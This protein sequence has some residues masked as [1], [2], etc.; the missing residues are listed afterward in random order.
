MSVHWEEIVYLAA[1]THDQAI[2]AWGRFP[3]HLDG[4]RARLLDQSD[5]E[6]PPER[7]RLGFVGHDSPSWGPSRVRL[8]RD[9]AEVGVFETDV[10]YVVIRDLA[11]ETT[12][13]CEVLAIGPDGAEALRAGSPR[14]LEYTADGLVLHPPGPPMPI[15]FRTF[16]TPTDATPDFRF[17]VIGD[18]GTGVDQRPGSG[19]AQAS[20]ARAMVKAAADGG[21]PVRFVLAA[22]DVIYARGEKAKR[23]A[24]LLFQTLLN[25]VQ[26]NKAADISLDSGNED[27]EWYPSFFE[28]Y[29]ELLCGIPFFPAL[30]NHDDGNEAGDDRLQ[31]LDNLF[32][33]ERFSASGTSSWI[34]PMQAWSRGLF[35][36]FRFGKD[37]RFVALDT[38]AGCRWVELDANKA[39]LDAAFSTGP[40]FILPF[41]HHPP[42]CL[43]P[44]HT[45]GMPDIRAP[46]KHLWVE[47]RLRSPGVRAS[48]WGHEHNYQ[49]WSRSDHDLFVAGASGKFGRAPS[50]KKMERAAS[51][52]AKYPDRPAPVTFATGPSFLD[53]RYDAATGTLTV[54]PTPGEGHALGYMRPDDPDHVVIKP[55]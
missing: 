39:M 3:L 18:S 7:Q 15:V 51:K 38:T 32:L 9:D 20:V 10:N 1:L 40:K 17:F 8:L 35:Y 14:R 6:I 47:G 21:P 30:G 28:P 52:L 27:D 25:L 2:L 54:K 29:R 5:P 46:R 12:Y 44:V 45:Y 13:R 11:P 36:S 34:D 33:T 50:V 49:H 19:A 55:A 4:D 48:F 53:C 42:F 24:L 16:P 26:G 23:M 22:G 31:F 41:G 43:G 37:F